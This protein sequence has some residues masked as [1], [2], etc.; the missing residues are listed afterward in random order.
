MHI[1]NIHGTCICIPDG[2][3][4]EVKNREGKWWYRVH[5]GHHHHPV[6]S[7]WIFHANSHLDVC[8]CIS[9]F[10]CNNFSQ[11]PH[12]ND[13]QYCMPLDCIDQ[14]DMANVAAIR[15]HE[16]ALQMYVIYL[17]D[18]WQV[19]W[20]CICVNIYGIYINAIQTC[21]YTFRGIN[22]RMQL[23]ESFFCVRMCR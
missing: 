10:P 3:Q 13:D 9:V 6:L 20:G 7:G 12:L 1:V 11:I 5:V 19:F 17:L 18:L 2:I 4:E 16:N 8:L 21:V 23:G 15:T 14:R 22:S